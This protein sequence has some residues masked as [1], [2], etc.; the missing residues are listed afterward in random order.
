MLT[1]IFKIR[2]TSLIKAIAIVC[3]LLGVFT[4]CEKST[5][6][7][8]DLGYQYFPLKTGNWMQ[9]QVDSIYYD[10][11]QNTVD[12]LKYQLLEFL[13]ASYI[14][15]QGDTAYELERY[16]R[17]EDGEKWNFQQVWST[18][19]NTSTAQRTEDNTRFLK[20]AFPV[21]AS[22][23]WNGNAYNS[24]ENQTYQY[25][26]VH[27]P[28]TLASSSFDSTTTVMQM[29]LIT[30]I[31]ED[32]QFEVYAKEIGLVKKSFVA[33]KKNVEGSIISGIHYEYTY[34]AHGNG[35]FPH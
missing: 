24:L 31:S 6:E 28:F 34:L 2:K 33:L 9:Y 23:K 10:D 14:D 20:L 11:F 27:K 25:T 22:K 4:S 3:T 5:K 15:N 17:F 32:V 26:Q 29:N 16:Q 35:E 19:R 21:K 18:K 13:L 8:M 7:P 1:S 30:L 12:T